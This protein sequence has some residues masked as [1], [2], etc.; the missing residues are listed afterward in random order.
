[1]EISLSAATRLSFPRGIEES[2]I[3][4]RVLIEARITY[5]R[6]LVRKLVCIIP[7]NVVLIASAFF[8]IN[9]EDSI[10]VQSK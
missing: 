4:M 10:K 3:Y 6:M 9:I 7:D 5:K 1:M 8:D 2:K